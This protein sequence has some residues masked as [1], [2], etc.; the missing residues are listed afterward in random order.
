[1]LIVFMFK[2]VYHRL[3]TKWFRCRTRPDINVARYRKTISLL[4]I[5][6]SRRVV[7]VIVSGFEWIDLGFE[8]LQKHYLY[9]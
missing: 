4:E 2:T 1:M 8:I 3:E 6:V 5:I 9:S 7:V